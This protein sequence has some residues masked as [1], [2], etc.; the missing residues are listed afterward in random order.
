MTTSG[1]YDF[2]PSVG[3]LVLDAFDRVQL[4]PTA[5]LTEHLARA[6]T[7]TN[8][9]LAQWSNKQVNL[10]KSELQTVALVAGTTEY[11]LPAR[12]IAILVA[13]ISTTSGS[14]TTDRIVTPIST[15]DYG[16]IPSKTT[17]GTPTVYWFN[18][19]V[20]PTITMWPVPDDSAT[21]TLKLQT[22]VQIQDAALASG[23]TPDIPY[24]FIDAF[25]A[26]LAHRLARIYAPNLEAVRKADA[27]EAWVTAAT[28]DTES[29][30]L[31]IT[32]LLGG[33]YR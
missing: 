5:L 2:N 25:V 21:Y 33:Y 17:Q 10:W 6:A 3:A 29:V 4:R 28:Q 30:P 26:G 11:T 9:L 27:D 23:Q 19:Q 16:A 8:L 18:R 32:P 15:Y 13:Y 24:R 12:T 7:E 22:A 1:T 20:T 31:Y 14:V